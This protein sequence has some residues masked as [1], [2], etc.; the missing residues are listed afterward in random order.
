MNGMAMDRDEAAV[1]RF[2]ESAEPLVKLKARIIAEAPPPMLQIYPW[3]VGLADPRHP[4]DRRTQRLL[5]LLDQ[6]IEMQA[7]R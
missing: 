2:I 1:R 7:S 4:Y 3:G 6:A 5:D